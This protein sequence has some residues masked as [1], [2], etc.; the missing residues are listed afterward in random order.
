MSTVIQ[1]R[2]RR[3]EADAAAPRAAASPFPAPH[4]H[5][6][7]DP[8]AIG[9]EIILIPLAWLRDIGRERQRKPLTR[10]FSLRRA[11]PA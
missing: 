11:A 6:A 7:G 3:N 9:A 10:R 2:V 4:T 1:F 5:A 8:F